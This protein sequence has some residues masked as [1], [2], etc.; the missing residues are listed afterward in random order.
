MDLTL[1]GEQIAMNPAPVLAVAI[2]AIVLASWMAGREQ[3][4]RR[5][6]LFLVQF[7]DSTASSAEVAR[8]ASAAG[9]AIT[10]RPAPD[11]FDYCSVR[12]R[13]SAQF[14]PVAWLLQLVAPAPEQLV[15]RAMLP[16]AP[17][18]ELVWIRGQL[19]G[20]ALGL[21]PSREL[22]TRHRLDTV[23]AEYVT[24]GDA[25]NAV[26]FVFGELQNRF[27]PF[28]THIV[29]RADVASAETSDATA[30]YA[31]VTDGSAEPHITVTLNTAR[32]DPNQTAVLVALVRSLGR[33]A[34]ID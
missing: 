4:L 2:G 33:A 1:W 5:S 34:I 24:R 26:R 29:V 21:Y 18:S 13:T 16:S 6:R 31:A 3:M 14:N 25:T 11:P 10:L 15:I 12:Y 19:T 23:D 28:L 32:L 17:G 22:W 9:F 8:P 30:L 7:D 20:A 27:G